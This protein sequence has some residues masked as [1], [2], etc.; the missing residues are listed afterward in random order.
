MLWWE[1]SLEL[2]I[3]RVRELEKVCNAYEDRIKQ[4]DRFIEEQEEKRATLF[5]ETVGL[6][7]TMI[8]A[9]RILEEGL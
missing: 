3:G 8:Q 7:N 9:K 4:L 1:E 5:Q 6:R 2:C